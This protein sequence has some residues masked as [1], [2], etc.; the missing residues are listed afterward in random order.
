M[1]AEHLQRLKVG[2]KCLKVLRAFT[3]TLHQA[4]STAGDVMTFKHC[5]HF[6]DDLEK[7]L[8][9]F[10]LAPSD[11]NEGKQVQTQRFRQTA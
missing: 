11:I 1:C 9:R 8:L 5:G 4:G 6:G 2:Q 10:R 7:Y 3:R